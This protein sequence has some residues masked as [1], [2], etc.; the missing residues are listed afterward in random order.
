[1]IILNN[2]VINKDSLKPYNCVQI[3]CIRLEYLISYNSKVGYLSR[4]WP[5]GF[6]FNSYYTEVEGKLLLHF[7]NCS[8]LL[9]IFIL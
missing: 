2:I 8:I 3:I 5:E 7:L 9:L 4:G 1:M 6:L